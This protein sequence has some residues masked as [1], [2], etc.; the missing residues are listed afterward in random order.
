M[1]SR[2]EVVM[3]QAELLLRKLYLNGEDLSLLL[4]LMIF[5]SRLQMKRSAIIITGFAK[6]GTSNENRNR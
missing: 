1:N 4:Q 3:K 6:G 2:D 5:C